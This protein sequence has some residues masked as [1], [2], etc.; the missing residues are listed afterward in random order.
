MQL[1]SKDELSKIAVK[2]TSNETVHDDRCDRQ[3]NLKCMPSTGHVQ[4]N[5]VEF[6]TVTSAH[7]EL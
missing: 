1:S 2:V 6:V 3:S 7:G 4:I 5:I